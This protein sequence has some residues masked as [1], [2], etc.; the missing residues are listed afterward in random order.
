MQSLMKNTSDVAKRVLMDETISSR[1]REI[2]RSHI[3]DSFHGRAKMIRHAFLDLVICLML[4]FKS[5]LTAR[6]NQ[7]TNHK[8]RMQNLELFQKTIEEERSFRV[9]DLLN[10]DKFVTMSDF[11]TPLSK[12]FLRAICESQMFV[13]YTQEHVLY[14]MRSVFDT[15]LAA[16]CIDLEESI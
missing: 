7:L 1:L 6:R 13:Q 5:C 14:N 4:P 9:Q 10:V 16:H 3:Y 15:F 12:S 11:S 2:R 8:T